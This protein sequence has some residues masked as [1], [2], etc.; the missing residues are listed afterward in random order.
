VAGGVSEEGEGGA[1][2]GHL[3]KMAYSVYE[4]IRYD[5]E[6]KLGSLIDTLCYI[7]G[8]DAAYA[9]TTLRGMLSEYPEL[10]EHRVVRMQFKGK[11]TPT[12][13]GDIDTML[14]VASLVS[15]DEGEE[16]DHFAD[17]LSHLRWSFDLT[18]SM[19]DFVSVNSCS[20][21]EFHKAAFERELWH[22]KYS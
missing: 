10:L 17:V 12:P 15:P 7:T 9:S 21:M 14:I 18:T 13:M 16:A 6:L 1:T 3:F 4:V 11:G 8:K 5:Y 22:R 19:E 20:M 2:A